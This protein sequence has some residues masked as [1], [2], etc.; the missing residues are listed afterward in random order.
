MGTHSMPFFRATSARASIMRSTL[1]G[2]MSESALSG[3]TAPVGGPLRGGLLIPLSGSG[4]GDS[5][6]GWHTHT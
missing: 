3:G 5:Q 2:P 1:S 6:I 4:L